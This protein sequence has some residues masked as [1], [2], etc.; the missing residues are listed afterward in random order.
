MADHRAS[1]NPTPATNQTQVCPLCPTPQGELRPWRTVNAIAADLQTA[2]QLHLRWWPP[3]LVPAG[4]GALKDSAELMY[5]YPADIRICPGCRSLFRSRDSIP[6][7]IQQRYQQDPYPPATLE[8]LWDRY[9][10]SYRQDQ[11]WMLRQLTTATPAGDRAHPPQLLEIGSHVGAFLAYAEA[12][13]WAAHG[14][15][16]GVT[17]TAYA[18]GRGMDSR[19]GT[20]DPDGYAPN[21]LDA[22]WILNCFEH[23]PDPAGLLIRLADILRPG[24][25]L[26][27]RTP[28]A[29]GIQALYR[30]RP[31]P[32]ARLALTQDNALGVP[33]PRCYSE[34]GL[35]A[36]L[37]RTGY[38]LTQ[39]R[40]RRLVSVA[41]HPAKSGGMITVRTSIR[42]A[43]AEAWLQMRRWHPHGDPRSWMDISAVRQSEHASS[44]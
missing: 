40:R 2:A 4:A 42:N 1:L 7:D 17:V 43:A 35:L 12:N 10:Q 26:I 8:R 3:P 5:G 44:R 18:Q 19:A 29:E 30:A 41:P 11:D 33:F 27:L 32:I 31:R 24:G 39:V 38:D 15:D 14:V 6:D 16:L 13:G 23:F 28:R 34:R 37:A 25:R 21:S 9:T 22:V 36:L 20:F